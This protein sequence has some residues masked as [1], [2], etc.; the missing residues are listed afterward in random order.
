MLIGRREVLLTASSAALI[1]SIPG[2]AP[3]QRR[4]PDGGMEQARAMAA[5]TQVMNEWAYEADTN[6]GRAM[7]TADVLTKDCRCRLEGRWITGLDKIASFYKTRF[8]GIVAGEPAPIIR[9]LLTNFRISFTSDTEAKVG[10]SL[11]L[12]T[13]V[14]KAPVND[15]C[16]PVEVADVRAECR[17]AADGHW[18]ISFLDSDRI[19]RRD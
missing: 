2:A 18:R 16:D 1:S 9:Q 14:G 13:K 8:A 11:L 3:A 6:Y 10:L 19:F 12:F 17:C 15:Y 5:I 7:A 4:L